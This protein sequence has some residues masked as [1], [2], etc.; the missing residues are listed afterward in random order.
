MADEI[1]T[2]RATTKRISRTP[3]AKAKK[4][5]G[6]SKALRI[7]GLKAV[8]TIPRLEEKD[9]ENGESKA[10]DSLVEGNALEGVTTEGFPEDLERARDFV[11]DFF[12]ETPAVSGQGG[13]L[14]ECERI[15]K[16]EVAK[17]RHMAMLRKGVPKA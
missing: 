2:S 7:A 10:L 9:F 13:L 14:E 1:R 5:G 11:R 16:D 3:G 15:L 17:A 8:D 12:A 4:A 6:A